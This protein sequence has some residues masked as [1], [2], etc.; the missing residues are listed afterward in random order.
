MRRKGIKFGPHL[1]PPRE[2]DKQQAR[3]SVAHAVR[4]GDLLPA[5]AHP[6]TDCGRSWSEGE[7][8]FE[9]DHYLG[10][11]T[12]HHLSVQ[13]VCRPCHVKREQA[14][15]VKR[16]GSKPTTLACV[17]CGRLNPGRYRHGRCDACRQ[18][19]EKY[20]IERPSR[21]WKPVRLRA[22]KAGSR[23][24]TPPIPQRPSPPHTVAL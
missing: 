19:W 18:Y 2:G 7:W 9:Y 15:G 8:W 16:G 21:L 20:G 12:G 17:I 6:C 24:R 14:R 1:K 11:G 22:G 10:Y 4:A 23:S 3:Q 13:P 5:R